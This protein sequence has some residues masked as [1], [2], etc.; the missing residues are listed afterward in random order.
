VYVTIARVPGGRATVSA[1]ATANP[2]DDSSQTRTMPLC[3]PD[4]VDRTTGAIQARNLVINVERAFAAAVAATHP[5]PDLTGPVAGVLAH[6]GIGRL[7]AVGP[8]ESP[9]A[10]DQWWKWR[11]NRLARTGIIC[12]PVALPAAPAHSKGATR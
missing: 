3:P 7:L 8:F 4:Q 1:T 10:L 9:T 11:R 12:L 5:A 2:P 6:P